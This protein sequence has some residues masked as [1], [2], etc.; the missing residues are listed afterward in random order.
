[1]TPSANQLWACPYGLLPAL[2]ATE[3]AAIP[4]IAKNAP[5]RV[6][7]GAARKFLVQLGLEKHLDKFPSQMS[8]GQQQRVAIA[9]ALV[10]EPRFI[11]CDEPTAS[12][13]AASGR[14]AS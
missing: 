4:L 13:D 10:H 2:T 7:N 9:R 14:A 8:G 11:V 5:E 12:L 3:N 6:A 1:M